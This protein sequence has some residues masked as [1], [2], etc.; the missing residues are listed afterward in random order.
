MSQPVPAV[1]PAQVMPQP[2]L[3]PQPAPAAPA[4]S[5]RP[6]TGPTQFDFGKP[7]GMSPALSQPAPIRP[8]PV[9]KADDPAEVIPAM[10]F[11]SATPEP[12]LDSRPT[13]P[14]V[15][16]AIDMGRTSA[17]SASNERVEPVMATFRPAATPAS[18]GNAPA[19]DSFDF[20]FGFGNEPAGRDADK[21]ERAHDPIADL[22][23]AELDEAEDEQPEAPSPPPR[24]AA[25]TPPPAAVAPRPVTAP[26]PQ[27]IVAKPAGTRPAPMPQPKPATPPSSDRFAVAPV[28]GL[29]KPAPAA[30]TRRPADPMDEIESLIGEA[31]RVELSPPERPAV[32]S[33]PQPA[34][35][36][37]PVVPPLTTGFAPRRTELKDR[38]PP[39]QSPEDAI[40]AAAAATGA[41]VG[42]L[43]AEDRRPTKR[44]KVKPPRS[45]PSSG[46]SRQY[47]GMAVAGTL[48]L[49]AGLGLY[50]VLG[51][52][53]PDATTAPVLTADSQPVKQPAPVVVGGETTTPAATGLFDQLQGTAPVDP[54]E[55]LVSRDET[56]GATP[57]EVAAVTAETGDV[58]DTEGG[59]ANRKVRTVTVRPDGTIVSGD[60][61]VAGNEVLPVD[62]PT[63]PELP[64][65][66]L[67]PNALLA[68]TAATADAIAA[69]I[70]GEPPVTAEIDPNVTALAP[71]PGATI[72][73][74]IQAP[75]P[76]PRPG[77]RT[78]MVGGSD[79]PVE[80]TSAAPVP[81]ANISG[82]G[83][84]AAAYVQLSSQRSEGDAQTSLR[85]A[86]SRFG[87]LLQGNPLEIQRADLGQK[88]IYYRVRL[89][90]GS[91]QE[92][93]SIC[94][95]IKA[96][97]GDC[98]ATGG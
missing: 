11:K 19:G 88:G 13:A 38:E 56:A 91:L 66:A 68:D 79:R 12:S 23:A 98:F 55:T 8:D 32:Q 76:L 85:Q 69:A 18:P 82:G 77:N 44:M 24:P 53:R 73:P 37:A 36:A 7:P 61:A 83:G 9:S 95:S 72:D 4:D 58:G 86:Q 75:T 26:S 31:V 67:E 49:A 6:A 41:R 40:L 3:A 39:M 64:G 70:A 87:S 46:G 93:T 47:L 84:E 52:G 30:D 27:V 81:V 94:A 21:P 59:L 15:A 17:P 97:G 54:N 33:A 71:V 2:Q 51:M 90:A 34:A 96:N 60:E 74:S 1:P 48:L 28:F 14:R 35:A 42:T 89:P 16:P 63:V 78:A 57:T 65:G 10:T 80:L 45:R 29:G 5:P 62:R 25:P 43:E 92:A 50:W 22:I 20:D